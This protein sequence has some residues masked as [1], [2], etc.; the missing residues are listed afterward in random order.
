MDDAATGSDL[1]LLEF[2]VLVGECQ[3]H[4][5]EIQA[6]TAQ[7]HHKMAEHFQVSPEIDME[8]SNFDFAEIESSMNS[9]NENAGNCKSKLQ[10]LSYS[11]SRLKATPK[12]EAANSAVIRI[13][14]NQYASL[15]RTFTKAMTDYQNVQ[16]QNMRFY[17]R[18]VA[19]QIMIK[20]VTAD[21]SSIDEAEAMRLV[22]Q[23]FWSLDSIFTCGPESL[24]HIL[25]TRDDGFRMKKSMQELDQLFSDLAELGAAQCEVMDQILYNAQQATQYVDEEIPNR[26]VIPLPAWSRKEQCCCIALLVIPVLL[27]ILPVVLIAA[28]T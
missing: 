27:T 7:V 5:S 20:C 2:Y 3:A 26:Q 8:N 6:K 21:G 15:L 16:D 11:T 10:V 22:H 14:Q 18:Q 4:I 19:Q 24:A 13:Q 17:E 1:I 28:L 12:D 9:I 25:G 23:N